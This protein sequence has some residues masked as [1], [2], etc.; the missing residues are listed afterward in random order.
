M[1][2]AFGLVLAGGMVLAG[3]NR[4]DAQLSISLGNPYTGGITIGQPYY[5]YGGYGYGGYAGSSLYSPAYAPALGGVTTYSSGYSGY[6]SLGAYTVSSVTQLDDRTYALRLNKPLGG[7]NPAT[8]LKPTT[9]ENGDIITFGVPTGGPAGTPFSLK[10]NVLQGD[11]YHVDETATSHV[12]NAND[13]ADVKKRF[14]KS[15]SNVGTGAT[16]YSIFDDVDGNGTI[17]AVDFGE[18]KKRFF[19]ALTLPAAAATGDLFSVARI[20]EEVLQ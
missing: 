14:F 9:T 16:A 15:T 20:A 1:Y 17:N 3:A 11:V 6:A 18:V 4:A 19:Q 8:G 10:L 7:G 12:V 5:G 2:R 13:F